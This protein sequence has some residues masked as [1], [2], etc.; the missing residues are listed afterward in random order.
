M[1]SENDQVRAIGLTVLWRELL[2]KFARGGSCARNS[3]FEYRGRSFD[4]M[5]TL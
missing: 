4:F 3:R 1:G 5:R 2:A